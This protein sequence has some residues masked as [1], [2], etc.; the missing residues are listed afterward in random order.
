MTFVEKI[1]VHEKKMELIDTLRLITEGKVRTLKLIFFFQNNRFLLSI[2]YRF[3]LRLN[4]LVWQEY[5][6]K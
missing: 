3:L 4:E 6:L 1:T 5:L 2:E